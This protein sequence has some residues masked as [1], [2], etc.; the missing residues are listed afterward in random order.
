M[1]NK[2]FI[3]VFLLGIFALISFLFLHSKFAGDVATVE[4]Q[5][6][7]C[8]F[9]PKSVD[10]IKIKWVKKNTDVLVELD[11][12]G[13]WF[14]RSPINA[15]TDEEVIKR[16]VDALTLIPPGDMLS[17]SDV[18]EMGRKISDFGFSPANYEIELASKEKKCRILIGKPTASRAEVYARVEGRR[19]IFAVSSDLLSALPDSFDGFRRKALISSSLDAISELEFRTPGSAFVKIVRDGSKW[20]LVQP[21]VAPA[22]QETVIKVADALISSRVFEFAWPSSSR[23]LVEGDINADGQL[24]APGLVPFSLDN[25]GRLSVAV[26]TKLGKTERIVFGDA[27]SSNLV[28]ALVH[29][30]EAVVKVNSSLRDIC[31]VSGD[32][33][34]DM[35]LFPVP[36][37][38]VKSFSVKDGD[39]VYVLK[40]DAHG[41]W[42]LD[43]PVAALAD[44]KRTSAFIDSVLRLKQND[45]VSHNE[46]T[47]EVSVVSTLTNFPP[48]EVAVS[49]LGG[50]SEPANFRSKVLLELNPRSITRV[51]SKIANMRE[52]V[53]YD[54]TKEM[55]MRVVEGT[56][57]DKRIRR[58][59]ESVLK[60]IFTCLS[61]LEA[62]SIETVSS[63]SS[64]FKRCGLNEPY[65]IISIDISGE[66]NVRKNILL[67]GATASGGRYAT[68]GGMDAI[69]VLPRST[70][71][72]LTQSIVD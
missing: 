27:A 7:L 16:L 30:G 38:A 69:F 20:Q 25:E 65:C 37:D 66:K 31:K 48:V 50:M 32:S 53:Q 14:L 67:G 3:I 35:R 46:E 61:N 54:S 58:A 64:D 26:R 49:L 60:N 56:Q 29:N 59:N 12:S 70:V 72:V 4:T 17:D 40:R 33:L 2:R 52:V 36:G 47:L 51:E 39:A 24:R 15:E 43:A 63:T 6:S 44:Q 19:N 13:T 8:S 28:Y 57:S 18:A 1:S 41:L 5:N 34:R 23:P 68:V 11:E 55:W 45:L 22:D 42:Q 10:K 9:N 71:A 62:S 21:S